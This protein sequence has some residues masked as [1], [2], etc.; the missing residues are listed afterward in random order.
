MTSDLY[1]VNLLVNFLFCDEMLGEMLGGGRAQFFLF[2]F[3]LIY[4]FLIFF[5]F[6]LFFLIFF[7]LIFFLSEMCSDLPESTTPVLSSEN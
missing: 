1:R 5:F 7:F 3:F 4:F 2:I 6:N